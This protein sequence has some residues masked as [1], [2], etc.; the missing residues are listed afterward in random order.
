MRPGIWVDMGFYD[1]IDGFTEH[2]GKRI[3]FKFLLIVF[4]KLKLRLSINIWLGH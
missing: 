4:I 1:L 3:V 2:D